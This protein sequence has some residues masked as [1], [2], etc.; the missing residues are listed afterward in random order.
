MSIP[1]LPLIIYRL[2]LFPCQS[3]HTPS[4]IPSLSVGTSLKA[5]RN[6]T[7][8]ARRRPFSIRE[9]TFIDRARIVKAKGAID[10]ARRVCVVELL[11]IGFVMVCACGHHGGDLVLVIWNVSSEEISLIIFS[12]FLRPFKSYKWHVR[13][14]EGG[15]G[16]IPATNYAVPGTPGS[17]PPA[18]ARPSEYRPDLWVCQRRHCPY[19]PA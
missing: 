17:P 5:I 10:G 16:Y 4:T 7:D 15:G 12:Y 11:E 19:S 13:E 8:I 1:S 14:R 18:S 2:H 9:I 6:V 3:I